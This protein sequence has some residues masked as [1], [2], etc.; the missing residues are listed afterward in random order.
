MKETPEDR[1]ARRFRRW[2]ENVVLKD[3]GS[4]VV[5]GKTT[6]P[7]VACVPHHGHL[8]AVLPPASKAYFREIK[9][10]AVGY[11]TYVNVH[12]EGDPA[13]DSVPTVIVDTELSVATLPK[14]PRVTV[15]MAVF[16]LALLTWL[17]YHINAL[18]TAPGTLHHHS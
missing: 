17:L 2:L 1:E 5:M 6:F 13:V 16:A 15:A 10:R 4:S 8:R 11:K 9:E 3:V 12:V 18:R 7:I 14:W